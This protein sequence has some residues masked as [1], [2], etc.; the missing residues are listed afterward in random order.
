MKTNHPF[1]LSPSFRIFRRK[2]FF[3]VFLTLLLCAACSK[4]DGSGDEP[5][6]APSGPDPVETPATLAVPI[7]WEK[8]TVESFNLETGAITLNFDGEVPAFTEGQSAIVV[9][10]GDTIAYIRVVDKAVVNGRTASLQTT[11]GN[12]TDLFADQSF[13]LSFAP[14]PAAT[15]AGGR[16]ANGAIHPSKIV[17]LTDGGS[18]EVIYD[19]AGSVSTKSDMEE[20]EV[21][22]EFFR[23]GEDFTNKTLLQKNAVT[24]SWA[25]G[26]WAAWLD[27][28]T[29]FDFGS[30][31]VEIRSDKGEVTKV[32]KGDLMAFYFFVK[33]NIEADFMLR[34]AAAGQ[35]GATETRQLLPDGKYFFYFP[36]GPALMTV[37]VNYRLLSEAEINIE[38]K[39]EATAGFH[40]KFTVTRGVSYLKDNPVQPIAEIANEFQPYLP[41]LTGE[42]SVR[43]KVSVY[44][45]I[46]VMLYNFAGPYFE[47]RPFLKDERKFGFK[48]TLG[49]GGDY[50]AWQHTLTAG[51]DTKA[52]LKIDF[53]DIAKLDWPVTIPSVEIPV[54]INPQAIDL[55]SPSQTDT[56]ETKTP[57]PVTFNVSQLFLGQSGKAS[58]LALVRFE[59]ANGTLDRTWA[60]SD[61]DGNVT[62]TW[63]PATADGGGLKA[64]LP[65]PDGDPKDEALFTPS[66]EEPKFDVSKLWGTWEW[67][68]GYEEGIYKSH[69]T[70]NPDGTFD[71]IVNPYKDSRNYYGV[72]IMRYIHLKGTYT[73][74]DTYMEMISHTCISSYMTH[75]YPD[76]ST[77]HTDRSDDYSRWSLYSYVR[78]I[79]DTQISIGGVTI[80][81]VSP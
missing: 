14:D 42:A 9:P 27:A 11:E 64:I 50:A 3:L 12:M 24:L 26:S 8:T 25:K 74:S 17:A 51:F 15:R 70:F 13:T 57:I 55:V 39:I 32:T 40:S 22:K 35:A 16:D 23:I 43:S 76:G 48:A 29:K 37:T 5:A 77:Y 19:A 71:Y 66:L 31:E 60:L 53:W 80:I 73:L 47:L 72:D 21:K 30:R 28:E 68:D 2:G 56:Y 34:L 46:E 36:V 45:R 18:P 4:D 6:P 69:F 38:G 81:R 44:P 58:P 79:S 63:T 78:I 10:V 41:T 61:V 49:G 52:G 1:L 20:I 62:V 65:N 33:G 67:E 59:T 54:I 75:T 7:D